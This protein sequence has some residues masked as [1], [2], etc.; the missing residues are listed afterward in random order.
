[1][2]RRRVVLGAVAATTGLTGFDLALR[3]GLLNKCLGELPAALRDHPGVR[4]AWLG[5]DAAKV[6]DTH[7]HVFGDGDSGS[8]LCFNPRMSQLWRPLEYLR[9]KIYINAAC[10]DDR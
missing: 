2:M 1:M 6:W 7:I 5:L 4:A 10:I 8:G 3:D 9:R